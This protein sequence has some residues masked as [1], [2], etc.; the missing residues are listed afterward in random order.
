MVIYFCLFLELDSP[1]HGEPPPTEEC[2][3]SV[4]LVWNDI[5]VCKWWRNCHFWV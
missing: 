2:Q 5:R 4:I 3:M 1:K